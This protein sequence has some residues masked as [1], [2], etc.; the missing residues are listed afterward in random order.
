MNLNVLYE[1]NIEFGNQTSRPKRLVW[2]PEN[3]KSFATNKTWYLSHTKGN[4]YIGP[5]K[6]K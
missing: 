6:G 1:A 4:P 3:S 2:Q 5:S